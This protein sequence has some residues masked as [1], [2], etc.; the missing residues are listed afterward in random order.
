LAHPLSEND[1]SRNGS[2]DQLGLLFPPERKA[3]SRRIWTVS[4]LV[5]EIRGQVER[6]YPD[7][8][9]EGEIS[10]LRSAASGHIYFTLKDERGQLPV[11]LFRRQASLLRFRPEA[12]LHVL[13][14]GR[15]SIY[16]ERG[17]L[18]F[19]AET[20]E[21]VGAGSLQF[22]FEQ[23]KNK[24]QQEGLFDASRKRGLPAFPRCIGVVT[25]ATGAVIHDFLNI[26]GRRHAG[27]DVM[28]FPASVQGEQ[29]AAELAS[30]ILYFN[31]VKNVDAIVI[32]RGGGSAEDLAAFNTELLARTIAG[33]ELPVVSA[34]GHETDFTIADFVADLRAPTP[35]AAAELLTVMQQGVEERV[36]ELQSRLLRACRYNIALVERRLAAVSPD[37]TIARIRMRLDRAQQRVDEQQFRLTGSWQALL[38]AKTIRLQQLHGRLLQ[39]SSFHALRTRAGLCATATQRLHRALQKRL[40]ASHRALEALS[41]GLLLQSPSHR[42]IRLR[43]SIAHLES[44]SLRAILT[45]IERARAAREG[46]DG[47]LAALSPLAVLERGYSLTF[48]TTGQLIH[49]PSAVTIGETLTTRLA[50]GIV[51]STVFNT[52]DEI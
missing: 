32:A 9:V 40:F 37:A 17:Q 41:G 38:H 47:R 44:R 51:T 42:C 21:P 35:S 7:C 6:A 2:T 13:V 30:G 33:S 3:E 16:E 43:Q 4:A 12:A 31:R 48:D 11:V 23:L 45:N 19:V 34:V 20:L 18:Q 27:L 10:N 1:E 15:I 22:A 24:L 5:T 26:V 25:S 46:F 50:R 39:Q 14:R 52:E 8:W 36:H 29:A 49:Q 28:L